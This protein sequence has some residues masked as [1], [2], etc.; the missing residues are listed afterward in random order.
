MQKLKE[1]IMNYYPYNE[2]EKK[3]QELMIGFIDTFGNKSLDRECIVGHFT[4]SG[5]IF[6]KSYTKVLMC[7]HLVDKSLSWL[8]GHS[9]GM[10]NLL[11]RAKLEINE[12]AGITRYE[13]ISEK[14]A[15][16][17][18]I[19]I[20]GHI[21]RGE[22]VSSHIHLDVAYIFEADENETIVYQKEENSG[23]RW[24]TFE[25]M[26]NQVK[27]NWKTKYTYEKL[28]EQYAKK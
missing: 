19:A 17:T 25:E 24:V 6:N 28:I 10:S 27:D 7:E 9:D 3:D 16:L 13:P 12:E 8:G 5:F 1:L 11:K 15:A 2:Q 22:Y 26:K 18:V 23:V 21:K 4:A 20:P 14:I